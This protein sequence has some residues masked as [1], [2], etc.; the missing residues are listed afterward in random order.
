MTM[1]EPRSART[2]SALP[3]LS[4]ANAEGIE[5]ALR[6]AGCC[7]VE[8][9]ISSEELA[10]VYDGLDYWF[11]Q[12]HA[13]EGKFFGHGTKRFSG[14][15]AKSADTAALAIHPEIV[16]ACENLLLGGAPGSDCIQLSQTQAIE[17]R[18][19]EP[20]QLLHRDDSIFPFEKWFE[21]IVNV[22][23]PLD[24]FTSANGA[25]RLIPGSHLWTR[26][27]NEQYDDLAVAAEAK[28]GSAIIWTG[29]LIHGGGAN[30]TNRPRRGLVFSYS[31][32]WLTQAEKLL[33]STPAET[34]R[35]LPTK[36]QQLIGY[37]THRPNLGWVEGRNPIEWLNGRTGQLAA[38]R[39]N[40]TPQQDALMQAYFAAVGR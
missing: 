32:G 23:W 35:K 5:I 33:L 10:H 38:N 34:A 15:F 24:D 28:A 18:P 9:A 27:E 4:Q 7:V 6:R 19:G 22:M 14:V 39:D 12:A 13:G 1:V 20:T 31:L 2:A 11:D 26:E 16:G 36:L 3:R 21:L 37:Q 25:T 29:A 40:L 17:I 30:Q 8:N